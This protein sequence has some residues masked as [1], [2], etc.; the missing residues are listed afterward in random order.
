MLDLTLTLLAIG[1]CSLCSDV[2][3]TTSVTRPLVPAAR[4]ATGFANPQD[5]LDMAGK[6][7]EITVLRVFL[8]L[9]SRFPCVKTTGGG[10]GSSWRCL[11][12]H[13]LRCALGRRAADARRTE[14]G[15]ACR[16][17]WELFGSRF[18][19]FFSMPFL[20]FVL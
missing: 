9:G 13:G 15:A 6:F 20:A 3:F 2:A 18:G 8:G 16:A 12:R 4:H 11:L 19:C 14:G 10:A 1:L 7:T 17:F 5:G